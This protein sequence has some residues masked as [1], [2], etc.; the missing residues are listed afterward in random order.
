MSSPSP[1][2]HSPLS[3]WS[4]PSTSTEFGGVQTA[5]SMTRLAGHFGPGLFVEALTQFRQ[6]RQV[7]TSKECADL[8]VSHVHAR[9]SR[10][11][12][13]GLIRDPSIFAARPP[14]AG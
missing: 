3:L 14:S 12:R 4:F 1:S 9:V 7:P 6:G 8:D 11:K 13:C 5:R 10:R 2:I